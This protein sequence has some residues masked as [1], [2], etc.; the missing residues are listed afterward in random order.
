MKRGKPVPTDPFDAH[1]IG[2][3]PAYDNLGYL[4]RKFVGNGGIE[5]RYGDQGCI[6]SSQ[7]RSMEAE[8]PEEAVCKLA[9]ELFQQGILTRE[10]KS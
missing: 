10:V 5:V 3:L 2:I 7:M 9:L 6:A 8:T 1:A 4:L